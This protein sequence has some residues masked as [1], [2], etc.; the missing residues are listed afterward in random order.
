VKRRNHQS[1]AYLQLSA[2]DA[3]FADFEK[4]NE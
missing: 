1:L 4:L 2:L 3:V